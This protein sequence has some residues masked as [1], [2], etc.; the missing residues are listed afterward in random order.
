MTH[1]PTMRPNNDACILHNKA[2]CED[3]VLSIDE[4]FV[5][6]QYYEIIGQEAVR[7]GGVDEK[8]NCIKFKSDRRGGDEDG[9]AK[10]KVYAVCT[11]DSVRG[12]VYVVLS[13]YLVHLLHDTVTYKHALRE[14]LGI[15]VEWQS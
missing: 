15:S 14:H 1:K 2:N 4:N 7:K 11:L 3:C 10:G 12:R 6:V 13:I 8:L 5:F 9:R